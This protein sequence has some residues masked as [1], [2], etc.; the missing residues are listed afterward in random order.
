MPAKYKGLPV[1]HL[2]HTPATT[3]SN[4]ETNV[5][6]RVVTGADTTTMIKL[7]DKV[8]FK[9]SVAASTGATI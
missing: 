4:A 2:I 8:S 3:T 9:K 7:M 1:N 5:K 6:V